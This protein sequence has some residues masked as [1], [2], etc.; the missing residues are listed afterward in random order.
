LFFVLYL[1]FSLYS[2]I[3]MLNTLKTKPL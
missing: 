3:L 1:A 2:I